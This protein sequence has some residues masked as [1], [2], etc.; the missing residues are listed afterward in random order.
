MAD[1]WVATDNGEDDTMKKIL[2]GTMISVLMA[3]TGC[4]NEEQDMPDAG[5]TVTLVA[6]IEGTQN[7]RVVLTP[8]TDNDGNPIVKVAWRDEVSSNPETFTLYDKDAHASIFTQTE[9]NKFRGTVDCEGP[10]RAVYGGH[11]LTSEKE[12]ACD[13]SQQDGELNDTDFLM[14]AEEITNLNQRIEFKHQ[15]AI[16]KVTFTL[17]GQDVDTYVSSF[18]MDGVKQGATGQSITVERTATPLSDDIYVFLP[19]M[20]SYN[21][22]ETL[23]FTAMVSGLLAADTE[24]TGSITI[25]ADMK[26][27]AGKYYTATVALSDNAAST[28]CNLPKGSEFNAAIKKI[29]EDSGAEVKKIVFKAGETVT[30]GTRIGNTRA[31]AKVEGSTL[32]IYTAK[33]K[34]KFNSDCT[35]MFEELS[36]IES[37]NWG[38]D[39]ITKGVA[40]MNYMF[41]DCKKLTDI[42]FPQ[43]FSVEAAQT[44]AGMFE[45]CSAI[46][47]LYLTY[48]EFGFYFSDMSDMFKGCASLTKIE[49]ETDWNTGKT[50]T[51]KVTSMSGMFEGCKSLTGVPPLDV[52]SVTNM[53]N[54]FKGCTSLTKFNVSWNNTNRL[55]MS[56]MFEGCT[57]LENVSFGENFKPVV[58]NMVS[59]FKS[60]SFLKTF[61]FTY[62]EHSGTL[63]MSE[64]FNECESLE[65]FIAD[66]NGINYVKAAYMFNGCTKLKTVA[67]PNVTNRTQINDMKFM[68]YDCKNLETINLKGLYIGDYRYLECEKAFQGVGS[69]YADPDEDSDKKTMIYIMWSNKTNFD[70]ISNTGKDTAYV[71]FVIE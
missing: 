60:C 61:T 31:V 46:T 26:I 5:R 40:Y 30:G 25:P 16:L 20:E 2:F 7:A 37:I 66:L 48:F 27:E 62:T 59:M 55:S 19:A 43:E 58:L 63:N 49:M 52:S 41:K 6:D 57:L 64:M 65:N 51:S 21:S 44:M 18:T 9:G 23:S 1:T 29:I 71:N 45:N 39:I 3:M 12:I 50:M 10:Y 54:M 13:F 17:D 28:N 69:E 4:Q 68:F 35:S 67:F 32:T 11:T 33:S 15:T 14:M 36:T 42:R 8:D 34:F 70:E 24:C 22:G 47:E 38:S 53:G 56:S